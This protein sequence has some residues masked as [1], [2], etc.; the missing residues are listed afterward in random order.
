MCFAG[1]GSGNIELVR[2][3]G[4]AAFFSTRDTWLRGKLVMS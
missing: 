3:L 1:G 2:Q 4:L